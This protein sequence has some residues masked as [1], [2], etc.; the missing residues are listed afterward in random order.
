MNMCMHER[1]CACLMCESKREK[2]YHVMPVFFLASAMVG[3][4]SSSS[5]R[6]VPNLPIAVR[7][8]PFLSTVLDFHII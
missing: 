4:C 3:S 6:A 2:P 7:K 5:Y 8:I 1:V